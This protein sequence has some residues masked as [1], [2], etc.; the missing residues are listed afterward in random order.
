MSIWG[1]FAKMNYWEIAIKTVMLK[2]LSRF[3]ETSS[4]SCE[5]MEKE[6]ISILPLCMYKCYSVIVTLLLHSL[7]H[8]SDPLCHNRTQV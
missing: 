4:V 2:L 6:F 7:V 3:V 5:S 1:S 8:S